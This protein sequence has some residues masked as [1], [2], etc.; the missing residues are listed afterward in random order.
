MDENEAEHTPGLCVIADFK[1]MYRWRTVSCHQIHAYVCEFDQAKA[2]AHSGTL[3]DITSS[4]NAP[5][6]QQSV[7]FDIEIESRNCWAPS[8]AGDYVQYDFV[9]S[10]LITGIRI[11]N[12]GSEW[13]DT[14]K[15]Q[16]SIDGKQWNL[17]TWTEAYQ[18]NGLSTDYSI[19]KDKV[20]ITSTNET[21]LVP[22]VTGTTQSVTHWFNSRIEARF[23][24]IIPI[25]G[26]G[27]MKMLFEVFADEILG[28]KNSSARINRMWPFR[29]EM[30]RDDG[31]GWVYHVDTY[32]M[33][34]SPVPRWLNTDRVGE[35]SFNY[36]PRSYGKQ[37][38]SFTIEDAEQF[39][40]QT[41]TIYDLQVPI[42]SADL[43]Y[44]PGTASSVGLIP[45]FLKVVGGSSFTVDLEFGEM[46]PTKTTVT[47]MLSNYTKK[48]TDIFIFISH[49]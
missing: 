43:S 35:D 26:Q 14:Y 30:E 45:C 47:S 21:D 28:N 38:V 48:Y 23:V 3:K 39:M 20:Q 46:E 10:H 19:P 13:V 24:R 37:L 41:S 29:I 36:L 11:V 31:M 27:S 49:K 44:C 16:Y 9:V 25:S 6:I 12:C 15:V 34:E 4:N 1:S 42:L 2:R 18:T 17:Y 8:V 33:G 7:F 40:T 22:G 5:D 32:E